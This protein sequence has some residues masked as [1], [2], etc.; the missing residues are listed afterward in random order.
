MR[1]LRVL[2]PLAVVLLSSGCGYIHFGRLP[3]VRS[4]PVLENAYTDLSIQH[5]VLKQELTLARKEAEALR[6]ALDRTNIGALTESEATKRLEETTHELAA[7]RVSYAKLQAERAGPSP[8]TEVNSTRVA[9]LEGENAELRRQLD[10][11]R[12]ENA[13][14]AEK[15]KASVAETEQA[16]ASLTQLNGDLLVQKE[17]RERAEQATT[18]LRAQLEAV[19]ARAGR[20]DGAPSPAPSVPAPEPAA[21]E[22]AP[23]S[24]A[25]ASGL[26]ALREAKS[27]PSE[28]APIAELRTNLARARQAAANAAAATPPPAETTPVAVQ[29]AP[30]EAPSTP[31]AAA[32][33]P[34]ESKP[35]ARTYTVQL[36]DTL[37]KI[38]IRF[39]G[40]PDQW[41]KIYDANS[42]LLSSG[43]GLKAGMTIRIP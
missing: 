42:E 26:S 8:A 4:D 34:A 36:G 12:Q 28:A 23:V 20:A 18:A 21:S 37:E 27:P 3:Q 14:L 40:A 30:T 2:A 25:P 11:S 19:M 32:A 1:Y 17:A 43:Q 7:L 5:K 38:S 15:L 39:Y 33:A 24:A 41:S 9:T 35:A 13:A 22:S 31:S 29:S 10:A 16:H 6:T